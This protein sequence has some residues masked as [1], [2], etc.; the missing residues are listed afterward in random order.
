MSEVNTSEILLARLADGLDSTAKMTQA[1]LSDLRESEADF[2]AMKT[3]LN[4]LKEN[5]RGLSEL[6]RDGG[7]SAIMTRVALIEQSIE[8]IKAWMDNH[9]DVHHRLKKDFSEIRDQMTRIEAR[10]VTV[11]NTLREMEAE[12][13]E[14]ER[15]KRVSIDREMDLVHEQKKND[16]KIRAERHSAFVKVV[17]A[18][19]IGIFGL[20]SGYLANSCTEMA[21]RVMPSTS[22]PTVNSP[23]GSQTH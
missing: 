6:L 16:D 19:L 17:T 20:V 1:L 18:V 12:E 9:V 14:K 11:E 2:A 10:L 15:A 13:K 3:E 5:V 4:I 8:N 23:S 7:T 22:A 21:G